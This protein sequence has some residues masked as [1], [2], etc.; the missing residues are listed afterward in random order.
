MKTKD[1]ILVMAQAVID[2]EKQAGRQAGQMN[3][4]G[5]LAAVESL[6]AMRRDCDRALA[7]DL[8]LDDR[9]WFLEKRAMA[10]KKQEALGFFDA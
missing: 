3:R 10:T 1:E 5:E 4:K 2:L 7:G 6:R 9:D 8:P